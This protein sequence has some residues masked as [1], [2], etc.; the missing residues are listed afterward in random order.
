M[1]ETRYC[2][3]CFDDD[4]FKLADDPQGEIWM[5]AKCKEMFYITD[6]VTQTHFKVKLLDRQ[7]GKAKTLFQKKGLKECK[8]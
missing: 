5:C 2:P 8:K 3:Y 7:K 1:K 6:A 4:I